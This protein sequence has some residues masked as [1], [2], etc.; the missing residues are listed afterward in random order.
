MNARLSVVVATTST[1]TTRSS[2]IIGTQQPLW[3]PTSRARRS[4]TSDELATSNTVTGAAS[5]TALAIPEGS[6]RRS[7]STSLHQSAGSPSFSA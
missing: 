5:N 1:P 7:T 3:A 4:E 6:L 2:A